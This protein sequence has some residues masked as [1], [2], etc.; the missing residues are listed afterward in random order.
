MLARCFLAF[1]LAC[2]VRGFTWT[3]P[4]PAA[5]SRVCCAVAPRAARV[6]AAAEP[7]QELPTPAL[8]KAIARCGSAA[9]AADVAAEAGQD[10]DETRRQLLVLARLV[11]AELQVSDDGELLFVFDKPGALRRALRSQSTCL[12]I[13]A[14]SWNR[15]PAIIESASRPEPCPERRGMRLHVD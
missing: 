2:G 10:I 14:G 8:L 11:A 6:M 13:R 5:S 3:P 12:E 15:E 1:A 9:T 4:L 7:L